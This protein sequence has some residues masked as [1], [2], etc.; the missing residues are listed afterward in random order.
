MRNSLFILPFDHRT[1]FKRDV[2]GI[3]GRLSKK[4]KQEI[5]SL[6]EV[7]FEAFLKSIQ[8]QRNKKDFAVLVDE[9]FGSSVIKRAKEL[10]INLC[11]PVEKS[12]QKEFQFEYD[13]DFASHIKRINPDFVKVLVRYDPDKKQLNKRQLQRLSQLSL[14][15]QKN[16]YPLIFELLVEMGANYSNDSE[17]ELT[18]LH[19]VLKLKK[20]IQ[21]ISEIKER[22]K[23][24]IWKME[25]FSR[26][27]WRE[28]VKNINKDSRII[29]LGRG[30]NTQRVK[31]WLIEASQFKE[32]I[33]FAVGRTVFLRALQRYKQG[34]IS[35]EKAR[36]LISER[37][38]SLLSLWRRQRNL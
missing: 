24:D 31:R 3:K 34:R 32:I 2:L 18:K 29:V 4:Q 7:I 28:I 12:G 11:L 33:G 8:K 14:F 26:R 19:P 10:G 37:F 20:T 1:S 15:C 27:Q 36:D 21:A 17:A 6:K 35:R 23:V 16:K 22:V 25:G 5:S 13:K 38:L 30:E 9:E